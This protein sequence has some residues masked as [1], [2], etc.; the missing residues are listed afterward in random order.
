MNVWEDPAS[1][2]ETVRRS[3]RRDRWLDQPEWIE[4]WSEKGTVRGT[5]APVLYED[6]VTFRVI[7]GYGS[8]TALMPA[9]ETY[10][11]EKLL[12]IL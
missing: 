1:Y 10:R 8:A 6:G 7:H 9:R 4:I 12:T 2:V 5:L 11:T 3:C